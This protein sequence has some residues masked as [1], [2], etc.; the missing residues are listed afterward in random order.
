MH[1]SMFCNGCGIGDRQIKAVPQP[2]ISLLIIPDSP[3]KSE[4]VFLI[5]ILKG[6]HLT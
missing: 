5:N 1:I 3:R 2:F 4:I 6:G